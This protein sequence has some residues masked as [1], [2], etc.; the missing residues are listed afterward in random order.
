MFIYEARMR[1]K[2]EQATRYISVGRTSIMSI[3]KHVIHGSYN[4]I[5]EEIR[6]EER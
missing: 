1:S 5:T 4:E 2:K 3:I 6:H